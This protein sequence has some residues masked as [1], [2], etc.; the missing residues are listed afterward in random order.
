[1]LFRSG[2]GGSVIGAMSGDP[3]G[4]AIG[5][6]AGVTA[7]YVATKAMMS[8]P[9]Q[10]YLTKGIAPKTAASLSAQRIPLSAIQNV[11]GAQNK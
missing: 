7:P 9:M 6:G 8:D 4:A 10:R 1:M 11:I 2:G 5:F 3:A